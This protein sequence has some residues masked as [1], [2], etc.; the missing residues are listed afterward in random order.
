MVNTSP[1]NIIFAGVGGQGNILA[2]HLLAEAALESNYSVLLTE[3]FGA[4]TRGGSVFSCVRI[5]NACAPLPREHACQV[6]VGLEPL[7]CLRLCLRYLAPGGWAIV[8][9]RPWYPVD[10]GTGRM[11]YPKIDQVLEGI[12]KLKGNVIS[13]DATSVA[14][15][16]G[17]NRMMNVV[18]LGGLMAITDLEIDSTKFLIQ[19]EKRWSPKIAEA[20]QAA[21]LKGFEIVHNLAEPSHINM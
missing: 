6:I 13:F 4:A 8:N 5:G 18:L 19:I 21:F 16:L 1:K 20:N 3:T 10:V 14:E 17:S 9:S 15:E 2:S 12:R 11:E 7:E